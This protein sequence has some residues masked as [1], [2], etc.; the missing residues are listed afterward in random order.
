MHK[1]IP[2]VME[3]HFPDESY[4]SPPRKPGLLARLSPRASLLLGIVG[5]PLP[6]LMRMTR[7]GKCDDAAWV[8][9]SLWVLELLESSGFH[10]E[11]ENLGALRR[12]SGP[13]V[14]VANHMSTLET[15]VLPSII[16]P[17]RP[18]TFVVKDSLVRMPAFGPIMRGRDPVV[19]GR[20]NPR[21]DLQTVLRE[22][23]KRLES[24]VSIVVFPQSTR[25]A[26]LEMEHFNSI[27]VKLARAAN[28]PVIPLALKTDAWGSGGK[29]KEFGR[30]RP[31]M[32]VR[33]HFAGAMD[34][35]GNGK[36]EHAAICDFISRTVRAWQ[37]SDGINNS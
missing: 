4:A 27:G 23:K 20:V 31:E 21:E 9:S 14:F 36:R 3:N 30:I 37:A 26:S 6:W 28:V 10:L 7:Q 15:F 18:L 22:G 1:F 24:G 34:I 35:E 16:R 2:G 33:F 5:G 29:I 13:C 19:V 25:S 11:I 32:P 8:Y 12:R 17:T